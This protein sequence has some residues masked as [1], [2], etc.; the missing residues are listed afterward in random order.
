[1]ETLKINIYICVELKSNWFSF[2]NESFIP[3]SDVG[4]SLF[5]K[6]VLI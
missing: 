4:F 3:N 1:M 6:F 5:S 2:M